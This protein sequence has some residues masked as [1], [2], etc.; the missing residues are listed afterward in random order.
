MKLT[1]VMLYSYRYKDIV[2][3]DR[4]VVWTVKGDHCV[5]SLRSPLPSPQYLALLETILSSELTT[6]PWTGTG[7]RVTL[8]RKSHFFRKTDEIEE[9]EEDSD[10]GQK[11]LNKS[12]IRRLKKEKR[13][14]EWEELLRV[15]PGDDYEDPEEVAAIE[16][17]TQQMGDYKLKTSSDYVVSEEQRMSTAKKQRELI[18]CRNTVSDKGVYCIPI[19]LLL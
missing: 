3:C 12:E 6:T 17:A 16:K 18:I 13:K 15:K 9:D 7:E 5:S 8:K 4:I 10:K 14:K 1:S 19:V 2:E 11:E